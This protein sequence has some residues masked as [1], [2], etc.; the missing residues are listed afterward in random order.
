MLQLFALN[1]QLVDIQSYIHHP[2]V[3]NTH[4]RLNVNQS[5]AESSPMY[6]TKNCSYLLNIFKKDFEQSAAFL[7]LFFFQI[8]NPF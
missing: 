1:K 6:S 4:E 8:A 5:T 3:L 2:A 7:F